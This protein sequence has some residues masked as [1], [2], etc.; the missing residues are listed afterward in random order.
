MALHSHC[1]AVHTERACMHWCVHTPP[2]QPR[3]PAL[4]YYC[5]SAQPARPREVMAFRGDARKKIK[6]WGCSVC[7]TEVHVGPYRSVD[8]ATNSNSNSESGPKFRIQNGRF[9][10]LLGIN[11]VVVKE[12][13]RWLEHYY[14]SVKPRVHYVPFTRQS[15][16][17]VSAVCGVPGLRALLA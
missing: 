1:V 6:A 7:E 9:G 11:S 4:I 13:S 14:R 12:E 16:K 2:P 17:E 8:A 10:K 3:S 15:F 5:T